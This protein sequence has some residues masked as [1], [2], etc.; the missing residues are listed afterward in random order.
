MAITGGC[1]CGAVR[2]SVAAEPVA[3]R[4][5][6]CRD[7]QYFAAGSGTVNAIFPSA[8]VSIIGRTTEYVSTADSGNTMR[9][10]FCPACGTPVSSATDARPNLLILRAGTL[11]DPGVAR[12]EMTIWT[13]SAP[14][15][16]CIDEQLPSVPRQPPPMK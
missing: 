5:C 6:W 16:A 7:C 8:A 15:W 4:V 2:Y 13:E 10:R 1:K 3:V 14:G 9:R 12:P 11:D